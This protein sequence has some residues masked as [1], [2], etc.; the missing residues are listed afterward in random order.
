[1]TRMA[2]ETPQPE[3]TRA[4]GPHA[5]FF[6][7]DTRLPRRSELCPP[8][9]PHRLFLTGSAAAAV[10]RRL[11]ASSPRQTGGHLKGSKVHTPGPLVPGGP[12]GRHAHTPLLA[13][14]SC[15]P[16][17][18]PPLHNITC[19]RVLSHQISEAHSSRTARAPTTSQHSP[20]PPIPS[21]FVRSMTRPELTHD[22]AWRAP[23]NFLSSMIFVCKGTRYFV[24]REPC[25]EGN[26]QKTCTW[27]AGIGERHTEIDM[28]N[29]GELGCFKDENAR[30]TS[31]AAAE[32]R[33]PPLEQ[34]RL[35]TGTSI[36]GMQKPLAVALKMEP[37]H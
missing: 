7:F 5:H 25:F 15:P 9:P 24:I 20:P 26:A 6:D 31:S 35:G 21:A 2:T 17:P 33:A 1:M 23:A 11:G 8:A 12:K 30:R 32:Q 37:H 28:T 29:K 34:V 4:P 13:H 19:W 10:R 36:M 18:S 22:R 14:V 3:P 16:P 27:R